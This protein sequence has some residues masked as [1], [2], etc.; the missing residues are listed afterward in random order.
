L[1]CGNTVIL[2]PSEFTP[3]S[4][5]LVV[6]ALTAAGLPAGCLNF[7]PT[8][9]H[10]AAA[11]TEF[12]VKHPLVRRVNFTGSDRVGRII[13]GWASQCLKQCVL[14]LGG[15][16]PVIVLEDANI[17]DAVEAVVFGALSNAGQICMSTERVYVHKSIAD[18][19][20][21]KLLERVKSLKVGNP[22][23]EEGVSISGLYSP[24]SAQRVLDT[25]RDAISKGATK[26]W[27]NLEISG[28]NKTILGPH[29]L[30]GVTTSMEMFHKESFGPVLCLEQFS[31]DE[32]AVRLANDSEFSLC[33]SVFSKD[34]MRALDIAREV[35]AG[36][37]HVNGP[38]VYIEATLPNGGTGGASGYGRFGGIAGVEEF[39]ERKI[40]SLAKPGLKY[41]F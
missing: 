3:K 4:Q 30:E 33:A 12:A 7:L 31:T 14:E 24:A 15:K 26:L 25:I 27:G 41:T 10:S 20:K 28:P 29:I 17:E 35:R 13:A 21:S 32:E 2:K 8:A 37:C 39:T 36:S 16:A 34:V 6:R 18:T 23:E 9:P 38:T 22:Q 11:V 40:V 1:I 5:Y 19:F